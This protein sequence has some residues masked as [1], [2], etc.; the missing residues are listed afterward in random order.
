MFN[1]IKRRIVINYLK[2]CIFVC[3]K[4]PNGFTNILIQHKNPLIGLIVMHPDKEF[5]KSDAE[6]GFALDNIPIFRFMERS[7][8]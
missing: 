2:D 5:G 8:E 7:K 4:K 6:E 1:N 3:R